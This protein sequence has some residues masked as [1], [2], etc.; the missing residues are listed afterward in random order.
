[1]MRRQRFLLV[2]SMVLIVVGLIKSIHYENI[3]GTNGSG[4]EFGFEFSSVLLFGLMGLGLYFADR[5]R[6][7]QQEAD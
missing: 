4:H 5:R 2:G 3:V 6:T 1:M 7:K